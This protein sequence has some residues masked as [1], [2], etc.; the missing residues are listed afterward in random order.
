MK[1]CLVYNVSNNKES[2]WKN[3]LENKNIDYK[4][5]DI[6]CSDWL[7]R[8]LNDKFD[9]VI[10]IPNG[11]I[12]TQ[13]QLFDER[14]FII[15]Y[16]LNIPIYPQ[17]DE[18]LV[19][20]NKRMLSYFLKANNI[21]HPDT[22]VFYEYEEA[23]EY[24][25]SKEL[26]FVTKSNIGASGS[27]IHIIKSKEQANS[28]LKKTFKG[29]GYPRRSGPNL[30]K[31]GVLKRIMSNITNFEFVKER[32]R[33]YKNVYQDK[34]KFI[35]IQDFVPHT[36]EWRTIK[37]GQS[38]ISHQKVLRGDRASGS[39]VKNFIAPD[40]KMLEFVKSVALKL[41]FESAAIDL[42]ETENGEYLINEIQTYYG[43]PHYMEVNGISGRYINNDNDWAFDEGDFRKN[44]TCDLRLEHAMKLLSEN[45]L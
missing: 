36:H 6:S 11:T 42:Y 34:E 39:G 30:N 19:Y 7:D 37:I 27:G 26:P 35:L 14:L 28:I 21:P 25:G 10:A 12:S 18:L 16:V 41:G 24:V 8:I 32:L 20:E 9:L 23:K 43:T 13:K 33:H 40:I 5:I 22:K 3:A 17:Y 4:E 29:K 1:I 15:H 2:N 38:Y 44:H 45:K 31:K